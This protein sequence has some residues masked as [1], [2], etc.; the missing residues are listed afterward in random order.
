MLGCGRGKRLCLWC[1][2]VR[3]LLCALRNHTLG[4]SVS[5]SVRLWPL[6]RKMSEY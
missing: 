3:D 5:L 4:A 1:L 2:L 6:C